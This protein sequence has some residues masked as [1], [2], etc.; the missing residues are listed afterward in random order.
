MESSP[1]VPS[2]GSASWVPRVKKPA[3]SAPPMAMRYARKAPSAD[4]YS[5]PLTHCRHIICPRP[6]TQSDAR[7]GADL[8]R[9]ARRTRRSMTA[10]PYPASVWI[11]S[12]TFLSMVS[13]AAC[14][15]SVVAY[16]CGSPWAARKGSFATSPITVCAGV[17]I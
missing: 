3:I 13:S 4:R 7:T 11:A 6:I 1:A 9:A 15:A 2:Q 14:S 5:S 8:V 17:Q 16:F 12:Y 10:P